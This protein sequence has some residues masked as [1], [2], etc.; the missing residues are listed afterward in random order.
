M[1]KS[2]WVTHQNK[3]KWPNTKCPRMVLEYPHGI[4]YSNTLKEG[5]W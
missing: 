4:G 5:G 1:P 2:K 3:Q